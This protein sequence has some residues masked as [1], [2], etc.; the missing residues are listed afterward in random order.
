LRIIIW[1]M[2]TSSICARITILSMEGI[3][4]PRIH[5][6]TACGVLNPQPFWI[7]TILSPF[8]LMRFLMFAPVAV[9]LMVG[10][11]PVIRII[12]FLI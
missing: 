10:A 7:S 5:L 4:S 3:V 11:V 12:T 8:A 1:S 9:M 6:N 2:V